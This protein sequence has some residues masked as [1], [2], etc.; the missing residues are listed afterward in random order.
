MDLNM[1]GVN[2]IQATRQ[3]RDKHPDARVLGADH[4]RRGRVGLRCHSRRRSRLPPERD[5]AS[6]PNG[7]IAERL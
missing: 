3:L 1:P 5:A 4:L 6:G 7:D 2:G